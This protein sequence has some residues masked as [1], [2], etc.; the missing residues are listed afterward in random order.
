M[1][2]R[3]T[4]VVA[5]MRDGALIRGHN[6]DFRPGRRAL[7]VTT[8]PDGER[9]RISVAELK[10]LFFVKSLTG[11]PAHVQSNEFGDG[12]RVG[13]RVWVVFTDGEQLA[14]RVLSVKNVEEG[15]FLFPSDVDSNLERAWVVSASTRQVLFDEE[16]T[17]AS[18]RYAREARGFPAGTPTPDDWDEMLRL[19]DLASPQRW[20]KAAPSGR[21]RRDSDIFLGDW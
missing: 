5:H 18:R 14:G 9:V 2:H 3:D 6:D 1:A 8:A 13:R 11:D 21:K 19:K 16:A 15:F 10:A 17:K 12:T 20:N 4:R 7:S